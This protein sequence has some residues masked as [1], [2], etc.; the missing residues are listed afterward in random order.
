MRTVDE[1]R[2]RIRPII[3]S[4]LFLA[5]QN[6]ALRGHRDDGNLLDNMDSNQN[7]I[8]GNEENFR[9]LLKFRIESGDI[10]R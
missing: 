2:K 8:V 4:L 9:E 10:I 3:Q 1:N 7:S 5:R 6:I